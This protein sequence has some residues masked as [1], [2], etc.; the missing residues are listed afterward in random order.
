MD[1]LNELSEL[2]EITVG[3]SRAYSNNSITN[4]FRASEVLRQAYSSTGCNIA[5]KEHFVILLLNT[6]N[7]CM[8]YHLLSSGGISGTIADVRL[9]FSIGV[10]CLASGMIIAHN[11]PSGNIKPSQADIALTKKFVEA[12]KIL[13]CTLLDHIILTETEYFSFGDEGML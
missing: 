9:A 5:L 4:S 12:G 2:Q 11:H 10:K 8:G 3:Y 13:D 1:K 6:K 7:E